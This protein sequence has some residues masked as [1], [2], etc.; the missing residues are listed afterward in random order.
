MIFAHPSICIYFSAL[1]SPCSGT[2][3]LDHTNHLVSMVKHWR[4]RRSISYLNKA[5]SPISKLK[6]RIWNSAL[7]QFLGDSMNIT[8]QELEN[9]PRIFSEEQTIIDSYTD[10]VVNLETEFSYSGFDNGC[11]NIFFDFRKPFMIILTPY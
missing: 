8:L 10:T 6:V 3:F 11:L 4:K 2:F 5:I 1:L 9:D 7:K